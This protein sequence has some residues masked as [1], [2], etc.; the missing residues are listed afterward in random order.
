VENV[1]AHCCARNG[2]TPE[3]V[4]RANHGGDYRPCW[5]KGAIEL[6]KTRAPVITGLPGLHT[7]TEE[8]D[9]DEE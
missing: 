3:A 6:H 8:E 4:A 5:C 7:D 9:T 2:N 1:P